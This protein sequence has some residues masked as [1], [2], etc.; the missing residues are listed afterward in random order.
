MQDDVKGSVNG[1]KYDDNSNNNPTRTT[2]KELYVNEAKLNLNYPNRPRKIARSQ[3]HLT[4]NKRPTTV[5]NRRPENQDIY[6]KKKVV[7]TRQ[8]Y[9]ETTGKRSNDNDK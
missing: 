7:P 6:E 2:I 1:A 3:T 8:T 5:E 9:G 4:A